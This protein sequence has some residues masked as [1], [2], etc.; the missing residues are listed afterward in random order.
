MVNLDLKRINSH[1]PYH[2]TASRDKHSFRFVTDFGVDYSISFLEDELLTSDDTYQFIIANTNDKKSP[3][4]SKLRKAIISIIYEFFEASNTTLLYICETGDSKQS[5]RNRL[6]E[7]WFKSSER[8]SEFAFLSADIRDADGILNYAAIISRL[9][10][11][12]LGKVISEF[13]TTVQTLSIKPE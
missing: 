9:D 12:R 11:P 5:M 13:L 3:R 7:F 2:V 10:N 4:D 1:S 8:K 6:F